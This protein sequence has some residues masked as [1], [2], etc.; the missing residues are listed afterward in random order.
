MNTFNTT[1][2]K[3]PVIVNDAL[4]SF[5][6]FQQPST[7]VEYFGINREKKQIFFQFNNGKC[8]TFEEVT[9]NVLQ[10]ATAAPSI[11]K[12]FHAN[13]KDK[14]DEGAPLPDRCI[15]PDD[16]EEE[17]ESAEADFEGFADDI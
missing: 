4:K 2:N 7:Y 11:G 17:E 5:E 16:P 13:I 15:M 10:A 9:S 1:I 12:F 14:Y 3:K 8:F 6:L